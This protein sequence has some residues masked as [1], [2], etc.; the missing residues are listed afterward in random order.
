[1]PWKAWLSRYHGNKEDPVT[2]LSCAEAVVAG[3]KPCLV[4]GQILQVQSQ[5]LAWFA[6]FGVPLDKILD[7]L[8]LGTNQLF[9]ISLP[10]A[11]AETSGFFSGQLLAPSI[12]SH[13][14]LSSPEKFLGD[15][16]EN[17]VF[18][19]TLLESL[20]FTSFDVSTSFSP[21]CF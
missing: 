2:L 21:P 4:T 1:M 14:L 20:G 16:D 8:G 10:Q 7:W 18:T 15:G 17:R 13:L 9:R 12:N 3:L 11:L 6:S 19:Q 5:V